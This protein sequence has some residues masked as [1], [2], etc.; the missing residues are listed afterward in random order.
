MGFFSEKSLDVAAGPMAA[1]FAARLADFIKSKRH[2]GRPQLSK[3]ISF[4]RSCSHRLA[5][6]FC[7]WIAVAQ[8]CE[9]W[10]SLVRVL[11]LWSVRPCPTRRR[12]WLAS[13][14]QASWRSQVERRLADRNAD[15]LVPTMRATA[16]P[17]W[18]RA[19]TGD[20]AGAST[21]RRLW[22]LVG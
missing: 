13:R 15:H 6:Y 3:S 18:R 21:R 4:V 14:G 11:L 9:T 5:I 19:A 20:E 2:L 1:I 12:L 22:P 17:P 10:R 7:F 8:A 16:A